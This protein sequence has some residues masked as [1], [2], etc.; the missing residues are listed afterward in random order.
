MKEIG[1]C[2]SVIT[3]PARLPIDLMPA[4]M[5]FRPVSTY[6]LEFITGSVAEVIS[7]GLQLQG[8]VTLASLG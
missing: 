2:P 7:Q 4:A 1:D 6:L 5:T 8:Q 3:L